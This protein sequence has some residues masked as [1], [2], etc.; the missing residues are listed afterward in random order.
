VARWVL[1][2][3][4]AVKWSAPEELWQRAALF[5]SEEHDLIAPDLIIWE[6]MNSLLAK[7]R[8][9]E[10][11]TRVALEALPVLY[12]QFELYPSERLLE[13]GLDLAV[14]LNITLF[15]A[16]Y[17]NVALRENCPLVTAD[18]GL[19]NA[20]RQRYSDIVLSLSELVSL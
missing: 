12:E 6:A 16:V 17:L 11:S 5:R 8:K 9:R 14:R 1:D 3:N 19:F 7:A 18:T 10:I 15:D 13:S 4:V 2:A 20:T